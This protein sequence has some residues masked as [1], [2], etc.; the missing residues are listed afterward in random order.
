MKPGKTKLG[1]ARVVAEN[2]VV[3]QKV[4]GELEFLSYAPAEHFKIKKGF[5]AINR[6]NRTLCPEALLLFSRGSFLELQADSTFGKRVLAALRK[7]LWVPIYR[8]KNLV[9]PTEGTLCEF[10]AEHEVPDLALLRI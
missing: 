9:Q 5:L 1:S 4:L 3:A 6:R 7:N 10:V 2:L 8:G